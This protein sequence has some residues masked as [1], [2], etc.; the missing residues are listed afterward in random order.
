MGSRKLSPRKPPRDG[1]LAALAE[2]ASAGRERSELRVAELLGP[3]HLKAL[4]RAWSLGGFSREGRIRPSEALSERRQVP[5]P[6][7]L[8][9]EAGRGLVS[10][11]PAGV[12]WC[13]ISIR[14]GGS[15]WACE[16]FACFA[17]SGS[18]RKAG[19]LSTGK[20]E[21]AGPPGHSRVGLGALAM[22][23]PGALSSRRSSRTR[24][25]SSLW[26]ETHAPAPA[27]SAG[28]G[29]RSRAR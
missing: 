11:A 17:Y 6:W 10:A 5:V 22:R 21:R 16:R 12:A 25:S 18:R 3:L 2:E 9:S 28:L 14:W 1:E 8:R 7:E 27:R 19:A 20:V 13:G 15:G 26:P 29:R 23:T 4:P 24:L